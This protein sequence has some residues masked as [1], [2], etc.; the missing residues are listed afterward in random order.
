M[1]LNVLATKAEKSNFY[2]WILNWFAAGMVP[3][4]KPHSFSIEQISSESIAIKLPYKKLNLNHIKGIHACALATLCEYATGMLL[5][6]A[7]DAN[8]YRIILKNI[9]MTYHY[10]AK[11]DV[12]AKFDLKKEEVIA[13]IVIP[14]QNQQAI[15]KEFTIEIYD[16]MQ[17]HIC[18]GLINWQVK[19]WHHVKTK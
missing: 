7:I 17:N 5:L 16:K 12:F 11:T 15:F 10:Q 3:F 8:L 4:N 1:K 18:T 13:N 6:N 9:H 2:L 14:L 19:S